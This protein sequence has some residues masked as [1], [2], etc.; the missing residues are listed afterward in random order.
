MLSTSAA[1]PVAFESPHGGCA[2]C[3]GSE[4]VCPVPRYSLYFIALFT[5]NLNKY[6][7]TKCK[8]ISMGEQEQAVPGW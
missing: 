5:G 4:D 3:T 2:T 1:W 6:P 8:S 7:S